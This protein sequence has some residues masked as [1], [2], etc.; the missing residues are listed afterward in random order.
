MNKEL[1]CPVKRIEEKD[2]T[3]V[4]V[5]ISKPDKESIKIDTK[6]ILKDK[7]TPKVKEF[8]E[9]IKKYLEE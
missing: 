1:K 6:I 5:T 8:C 4:S 7:V 9:K 3:S 2:P